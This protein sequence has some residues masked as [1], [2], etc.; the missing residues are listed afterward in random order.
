MTYQLK[1]IG[2]HYLVINNTNGKVISRGLSVV[3]A[4]RN[5]NLLRMKAHIKAHQPLLP[6]IANI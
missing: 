6:I 3:L 2:M 5:M 1:K 4:I